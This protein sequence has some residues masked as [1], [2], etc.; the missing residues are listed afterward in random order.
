MKRTSDCDSES[1]LTCAQTTGPA[2]LGAEAVTRAV[3][4]GR[5]LNARPGDA[6]AALAADFH[7]G[8]IRQLIEDGGPSAAAE[9]GR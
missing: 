4:D 6:P 3:A 9:G 1:R 5:P 2:K 7:Y 8:G